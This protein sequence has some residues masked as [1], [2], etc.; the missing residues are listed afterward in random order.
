VQVAL[1]HAITINWDWSIRA[2]K[3]IQRFSEA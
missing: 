2:S 1:F 3:R